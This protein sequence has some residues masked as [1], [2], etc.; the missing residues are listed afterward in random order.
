MRIWKCVLWAILVCAASASAAISQTP[1]QINIATAAAHNICGNITIKDV[2]GKETQTQLKGDVQAGI[3]GILKNFVDVGGKGVGSI[4]QQEFDGLS[5]DAAATVLQK[6]VDCRERIF[7]MLVNRLP[8]QPIPPRQQSTPI[9]R[10]APR[11]VRAERCC[12]YRLGWCSP[13]GIGPIVATPDSLQTDAPLGT[14][15]FCQ[16]YQGEVGQ[17]CP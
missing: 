8:P 2:H 6:G 10:Q 15:C 4:S 17:D 14:I 9:P 1:E 5:R 12:I 13:W 16:R 3:K 11:P 7:T